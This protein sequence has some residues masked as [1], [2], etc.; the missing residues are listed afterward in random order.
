MRRRTLIATGLAAGAIVAGG[1]LSPPGHRLLSRMSSGTLVPLDEL[2]LGA[3]AYS[4]L[5]GLRGTSR[6]ARAFLEQQ[7]NTAQALDE[8]L[9]R[10]LDLDPEQPPDA[11]DFEQRLQIAIQDDFANDRLCQVNDWLLSETECRAAALSHLVHGEAASGR[12]EAFRDGVI[13]NIEAWGPQSTEQGVPV[14][15][16]PDGHSGL[17]FL[18]ENVPDWLKLEI[19]GSRAA[20]VRSERSF[21]SGLY[22]G[23]QERILSE[24]GEYPIVLLDEMNRIRQP[25]GN[26][27]VHP[28]VER[29]LLAD[30]SAATSLCPVLDWGPKET[31]AGKV[32]NPQPDGAVGMWFRV[33]CAPDNVQVL[34]DGVALATTRDSTMNV[35]TALLPGEYI[36]VARHA[37]LALRDPDTQ[38]T[39]DVG[40][41]LVTD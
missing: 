39:I 22:E 32:P 3:P 2:Q 31:R 38:E 30:G 14:N 41:F 19:D 17:W 40:S 8:W 15:V 11:S 25:V 34:F 13:V 6:L 37:A 7:P 18:A 9:L 35:V 12:L 4:A 36:A 24:P 10:R 5:A 20:I 21:T 16:Q 33:E 27:V 29:A 26:F 23:I 1:L 28:K